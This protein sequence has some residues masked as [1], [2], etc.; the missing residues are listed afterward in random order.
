MTTEAFPR[1]GLWLT[2]CAAFLGIY[3]SSARFAL[4]WFETWP[5]G[6]GA[7]SAQI[8][9]HQRSAATKD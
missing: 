5:S 9:Y 3:E 2:I 8:N 1:E 7:Q 4:C 6:N